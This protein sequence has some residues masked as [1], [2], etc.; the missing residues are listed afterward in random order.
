M[1]KIFWLLT[2]TYKYV[3]VHIKD[4]FQVQL[5]YISQE[6]NLYFHAAFSLDS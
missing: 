1:L 2:L 5:F 3:Y 4:E 6:F